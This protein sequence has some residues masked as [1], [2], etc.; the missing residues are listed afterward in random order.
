VGTVLFL[1]IHTAEHASGG[2]NDSGAHHED[3]EDDIEICDVEDAT[4]IVEK[5]IEDSLATKD[6][7]DDDEVAALEI[8]DWLADSGSYLTIF[9]FLLCL[10]LLQLTRNSPSQAPRA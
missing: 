1:L 9:R 6:A 10:I 5:E 3:I 4:E 2:K 7:P 8:L